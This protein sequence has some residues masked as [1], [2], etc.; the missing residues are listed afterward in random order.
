MILPQL[1]EMAEELK[2]RA[3]IVKFNCNK[4][5]KDLGISL[6]IKVAP[7]FLLYKHGEQVAASFGC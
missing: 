1:V 5:N 4:Y 7:T 3:R 2:D 6:G